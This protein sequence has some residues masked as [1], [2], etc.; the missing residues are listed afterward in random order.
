MHKRRAEKKLTL[1]FDESGAVSI[2]F[3]L[4]LTVLCGFVALA[5][6][7]GHIVMVKAELQRTADAAALGG[8]AGLVPY[9]NPGLNQTPN[10]LQAESKAYAIINNAA[11]EV[12][13]QPFTLTNN[14]G[15]VLYGY[16]LLQA[17]TG[18]VQSLS[19]V[20]PITS[21]YLPEPAVKVTLTKL[22]TLYFAPVV[23]VSSP[24][25][26]TATAA[27]I[28]PEAYQ[29]TGIP[30]VTVAKDIVYDI[31][32]ED[33]VEIEIDE[34]TQDLKIQSE[35]GL[36]GWF[37]RDGSNNV[38]SVRIMEPLTTDVSKIYILP[39]TKA[40]LTDY[41][42][43]GSTVIIPIVEDVNAKT[44][45]TIIGWAAFRVDDL[46]AN[47]MSGSFVEASLDPNVVPTGGSGII[48]G[49]AGTPKLVSP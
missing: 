34:S 14:D 43:K 9:I 19:T 35:K 7:I 10:W 44:W 5:F 12:D 11:N 15:A 28:L 47:A 30:P 18:Y 6:D 2:V 36:A 22:V 13:N 21:T 17:P 8:A 32:G 29:T 33:G 45:N 26:V 4:T 31:L 46:S 25:R 37:N 40:T 1:V 27:A 39:G 3:A 16:W 42:T 49:V 41:I 24:T 23:G 38:P 48:G 20:R